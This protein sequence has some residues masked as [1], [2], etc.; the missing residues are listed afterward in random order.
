M[1]EKKEEEVVSLAR[2]TR[3][4]PEAVRESLEQLLR[5]WGGIGSFVKP[6]KKVLLK[7]NLLTAAAPEEAVTTHPVALRVLAEM[8]LEAGGEVY[9]GDSSGSGPPERVLRVTGVREVLQET[10]AKLLLFDEVKPARFQGKKTRTLPLARALEEVDLVINAG[11]LKT[12]TLTGLTA[13]VKNMYGCVVDKH[14]GRLHFEH[15]LPMDF[16]HLLL[17][18]YLAVKPGLSII[19]A[20]I[21]MEGVGPRNG[22]PRAVGLLMAATNGI[23]LDCV[24]AAITGFQPGQVTTTA[25]ARRRKLPGSDLSQ[26]RV[27]GIPLAEAAIRDFDRGAVNAGYAGKAWAYVFARSRLLQRRR[28]SPVVIPEKCAGC[29]VCL[30][31]CPPQIIRLQDNIA[32]IERSRCIRCYCCQELCAHGAIELFPR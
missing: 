21:A 7:P 31:H 29:A 15:P 1:P 19:D 27:E 4:Q 25:A 23:A 17:D 2:C 16:A 24:A 14:K 32:V 28:P 5:P 18:I 26:I 9:I 11:K 3:Y 8:A 22:R 30:E 13:A 12:H 6:G 20:V 10:G